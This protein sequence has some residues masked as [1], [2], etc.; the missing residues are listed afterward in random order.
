MKEVTRIA[1][2]G[3]GEPSRSQRSA[4]PHQGP[5]KRNCS[6][7]IM[8]APQLQGFICGGFMHL[9]SPSFLLYILVL[10]S[11]VSSSVISVNVSHGR[12]AIAITARDTARSSTRQ[13]LARRHWIL[14]GRISR[15]STLAGS[16]KVPS[17]WQWLFN[18][19]QKSCRN[20]LVVFKAC[21][22]G[23]GF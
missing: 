16:C 6:P 12:A 5:V 9:G 22:S 10:D 13:I 14:P 2:V 3:D 21:Q 1:I 15:L 17:T 19:N 8:A 4:G 23:H 7:R 18:K 20:L 11:L